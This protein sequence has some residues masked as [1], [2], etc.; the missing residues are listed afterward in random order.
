VVTFV[1]VIFSLNNGFPPLS[2]C[3]HHFARETRY[4]FLKRKNTRDR[5][6]VELSGI[7]TSKVENLHLRHTGF[8]FLF[9]CLLLSLSFYMYICTLTCHYSL[10]H[11]PSFHVYHWENWQLNP[12][13]SLCWNLCNNFFQIIK[14]F[15]YVRMYVFS[16]TYVFDLN[17]CLFSMNN[18]LPIKTI[19]LYFYK[20]LWPTSERNLY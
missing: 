7:P 16:S 12:Y 14:V 8:S 19:L 20:F 18:S 17:Y 15:I 10:T 2:P 5:K 3:S 13:I 6:I 1:F 11:S 9:S 4:F